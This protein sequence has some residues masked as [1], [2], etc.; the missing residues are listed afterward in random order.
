[1]HQENNVKLD[2]DIFYDG[3]SDDVRF[4]SMIPASIMGLYEQGMPD[5]GKARDAALWRADRNL[6]PTSRYVFIDTFVLCQTRNI[7]SH[8][9][10]LPT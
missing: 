4:D 7:K 5:S 2:D 1:M 9:Q 10:H 3:S 6:V 8:V